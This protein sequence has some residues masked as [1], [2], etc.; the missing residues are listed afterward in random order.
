MSQVNFIIEIICYRRRGVSPLYILHNYL[1]I[2]THNNK[3]YEELKCN[4]GHDLIM[5]NKI[6][7]L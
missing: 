7:C 4:K 1:Y 5:I 6:Q 3:I 2:H